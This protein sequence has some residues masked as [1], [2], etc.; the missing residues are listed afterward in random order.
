[1]HLLII[2]ERVIIL[3]CCKYTTDLHD[4]RQQMCRQESSTKLSGR[5]RCY[6]ID[7]TIQNDVFKV[8]LLPVILGLFMPLGLR[9][10]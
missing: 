1:M 4:S 9:L 8:L 10:F 5:L 6:P 7:Y 3:E 2:W